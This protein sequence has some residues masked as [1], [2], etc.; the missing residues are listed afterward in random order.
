MVYLGI[1][2]VLCLLIVPMLKI[3]PTR[4]EKNQ[5]ALRNRARELGLMVQMVKLP[6]QD[7]AD[8]SALP[9]GACYSLARDRNS[10]PGQHWQAYQLFRQPSQRYLYAKR[11]AHAAEHDQ[12]ISQ[13]NHTALADAQDDWCELSDELPHKGENR[14]RLQSL[15]LQLPADV[16]AVESSE[17]RCAVFWRE[18]GS[19]ADVEQIRQLLQQLIALDR[20]I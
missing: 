18:H 11:F 2:L 9:N 7:Q 19:E 3:L 13:I 16:S 10:V 1:L 14:T 6:E 5:M 8:H 17:Q 12:D 4:E 20:T 15:L